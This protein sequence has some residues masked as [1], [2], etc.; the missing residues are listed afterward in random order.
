[1]STDPASRVVA[2]EEWESRLAS[3]LSPHELASV[4]AFADTCARCDR[5]DTL[6]AALARFGA[7]LGYEYVLYAY[8]KSSY[9][10]GGRVCLVNISN[11]SSWMEEYATKAYVAHDPVR[12]ELERRLA[13]QQTSGAFEWDAYDPPLSDVEREII[14]RRSSFGLRTGFSAFCDS[15][16]QDAVFLVSFASAREARP[17]PRVMLIAELVVSHLNR[18]RKRLDLSELVS[19]LTK[20]ERAVADWLIAGKTNAEIGEI[21]G[22][23]E[24]TAKYHVAHLL[25][26]LGTS[27]RQ[28]AVAILIAERCL[29]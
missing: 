22:L 17:E 4:V 6:H 10:S 28:G 13:A 18:C 26:K 24:A 15:A 5:E 8:M 25:A 1:V 12:H 20:R 2:P 3:T 9:D 16:R 29:S 27:S 14:A 11:P 23:S 7:R 19:Q 21:L